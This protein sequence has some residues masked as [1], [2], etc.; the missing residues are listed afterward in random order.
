ML[1]SI[2]FSEKKLGIAAGLF[3]ALV[4]IGTILIGPHNKLRGRAD[5]PLP[6]QE[7]R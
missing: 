5:A 3:F 4:V 2:A 1:N 7:V 6:H